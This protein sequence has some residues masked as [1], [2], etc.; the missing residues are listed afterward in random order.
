VRAALNIFIVRLSDY[1]RKTKI[2]ESD[3]SIIYFSEDPWNKSSDAVN[4]MK[5]ATMTS[6]GAQR[7]FVSEIKIKIFASVEHSILLGC[8]NLS[9]WTMIRII[10][11]RL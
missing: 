4:I 11:P 3:F 10:H 1:A 2:R 6:E 9:R 5:A 7:R 8:T